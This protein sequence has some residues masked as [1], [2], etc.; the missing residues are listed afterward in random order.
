MSFNGRE[1]EE[2]EGESA[3]VQKVQKERQHLPSADLQRDGWQGCSVC[4]ATLSSSAAPNLLPCLHVV[5]RSCVTQSNGGNTKECQVCGQSYSLS[6]VTD[7]FIFE[8]SAPKCGGCEESALSGWC[9]QCEE[10]LCSDCVLAHQRVKVTRNHTVI[11]EE[12]PSGF[13]ASLRCAS[14][15]QERLKFFCLTCDELTCRDCQL[16]NHRGHSFLLLE[17]AL[18]SQKEQLQG[19]LNCIREQRSGVK[20]SLLDVDGRLQNI[21]ESKAA[22]K[23]KIINLVHSMRLMMLVR[24]R[25]L[26]KEVEDLY[27]EEEKSLMEMKTTLRSLENRQE[28]IT[29]FIQK[30]LST[31]GQCI[32]LH[33]KQIRKR[34]EVLLSQK[35]CQCETVLH[36]LLLLNQ[37]LFKMCKTFGSVKASRVP[38]ISAGGNKNSSNLNEALTED[39][40][41]SGLNF[42]SVAIPQLLAHSQSSTAPEQSLSEEFVC[43]S[44]KPAQPS[45]VLSD[46]ALPLAI[47]SDHVQSKAPS[48]SC[49]GAPSVSTP[50]QA[51]ESVPA[52][53]SLTLPQSASSRAVC[54]Q[55]SQSRQVVR[56]LSHPHPFPSP[57]QPQ[58]RSAIP[59][60]SVLKNVVWVPPPQRKNKNYVSVQPLSSRPGNVPAIASHLSFTSSMA[61]HSASLH[62]ATSQSFKPNDTVTTQSPSITLNRPGSHSVPSL[63]TLAPSAHSGQGV[64]NPQPNILSH[65]TQQGLPL[66]QS[67]SVLSVPSQALHPHWPPLAVPATGRLPVCQAP[68]TPQ[69]VIL[70]HGQPVAVPSSP[71]VFTIL[72]DKN[73]FHSFT[74]IPTVN[75]TS[76]VTYTPQP[77]VLLTAPV[78]VPTVAVAATCSI[79]NVPTARMSMENEKSS[80]PVSS[81]VSC[82]PLPIPPNISVLPGS[83]N[84]V[85]S[86]PPHH[87]A[88]KPCASN[89]PDRS[90][91][92]TQSTQ[93]PQCELPV[94]APADSVCERDISTHGRTSPAAEE[95]DDNLPTSTVSEMDT[96]E[97][98]E[99]CMSLSPS[100]DII[101]A[102]PVPECPP[103]KKSPSLLKS[104]LES[105]STS[106]QRSSDTPTSLL[107]LSEKTDAPASNLDV[108]PTED[109]LFASDS[110]RISPPNVTQGDDD[111]DDDDADDED[112]ETDI[113][114]SELMEQDDSAT[115]SEKV[116]ELT[117]AYN[118]SLCVS[119][120]RLPISFPASGSELPQFH[121]VSSGQTDE[122][123]LQEI[124]GGQSGQ[125]WLRIPAPPD[126]V[127]LSRSSTP[128]GP[129]LND[130]LDCAV[131]LSAG[132]TLICAECGRSFHADCHVPPVLVRPIVVWVCSL[133]QDVFDDTDPFSRDRLTEPYLN[134][135]DQRRC[136]QLLL[137]LMCEE[138]SYLLYK[139]TKRTAGSVEFDFIRGRL[140]GKQTPPYRSAAELVSDLWA[141]F[142]ILSANSKRR[143]SVIKLQNSFQERLDVAFSKSLHVSLLR[144]P[145]SEGQ[146]RAPETE[147]EKDKA[148]NTL[149]RMREFL[150]ANSATVSK[151]P[152]PERSTENSP[153]SQVNED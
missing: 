146:K 98:Q 72:K 33:K 87:A 6:E 45:Q 153:I 54:F 37:D 133:C 41:S 145:G 139:A 128:D 83:S 123:L 18:V 47:T 93:K 27:E 151:K 143:D 97:L 130:L 119:L 121:I 58:S 68:P 60:Q 9:V 16:I 73:T 127:S 142:D 89:N 50:V 77:T 17:E 95:P 126:A 22:A 69:T 138:H 24:G 148:N 90:E 57:S 94:Q 132:A 101:S 110:E 113:S 61:H 103:N 129:Q 99:Q 107:Q 124:Q 8:D 96:R 104:L 149:K 55:P 152:R 36:P 100:P 112:E 65:H 31:E 48:V 136:E 81:K 131:C 91:C 25:Q 28:H 29:A 53:T 76:V 137:T 118:K 44:L 62:T 23:K 21:K 67:V 59:G 66:S 30:I 42:K 14:H 111:D 74:P 120:L 52:H 150:A 63:S 34:V 3:S 147:L 135:Q 105:T 19:L 92:A 51:P 108:V 20:A 26:F 13:T 134:V 79:P 84:T 32:L 56:S 106:E 85:S 82:P 88:Q 49:A 38:F 75:Q 125:R 64:P 11:P 5:C 12:P 141:L 102:V 43:D 144:P 40:G 2:G 1:D 86:K 122:I 71:L 7:C 109:A 70:Q 116:P 4:G 15:R 80:Y 39:D 115:T 35:T 78:S 10:A 117:E 140:L 114:D 46:S